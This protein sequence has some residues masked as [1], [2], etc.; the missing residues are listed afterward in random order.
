[1]YK[2]GKIWKFLRS[3]NVI[4]QKIAGMQGEAISLGLSFYIFKISK[5]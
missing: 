2:L 1:M 4:I 5:T 3:N